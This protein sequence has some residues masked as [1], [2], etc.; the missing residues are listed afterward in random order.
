MWYRTAISCIFASPR[1]GLGLS[2]DVIP[3]RLRTEPAILDSHRLNLPRWANLT[4]RGRWQG[5]TTPVERMML[6]CFQRRNLY[7][8]RKWA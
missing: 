6:V 5:S 2:G 7:P 8:G 3:V 4:Y 1:N